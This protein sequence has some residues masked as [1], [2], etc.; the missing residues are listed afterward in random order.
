MVAIK[1]KTLR[2][3]TLFGMT[4]EV[5]LKHGGET[6]VSFKISQ[7][8]ETR[9]TEGFCKVQPFNLLR[10]TFVGLKKGRF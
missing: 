6:F 1:P 10:L 3:L 4:L 9:W 5:T 7:L 8:L 2:T